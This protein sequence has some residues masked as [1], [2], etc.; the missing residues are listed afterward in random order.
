MKLKKIYVFTLLLACSMFWGQKA[1]AIEDIAPDEPIELNVEQSQLNIEPLQIK[2]STGFRGYLEHSEYLTGD[3]GG[4]RSKLEERGVNIQASYEVNSFIMRNRQEGKTKGTYQGVFTISTEFD[5]E[6]LGLWKGGTLF[7]SVEFMN[8]GTNSADFFNSFSEINSNDPGGINVHQIGE[9]WYE[10]V[11]GDDKFSL[12]VGRQDTNSEF[13]ALETGTEFIGVSHNIIPNSPILNPPCEQMGVRAKLKI[14]ENSYIQ[15][16]IFDAPDGPSRNPKGFFNGKNGYLNLNEVHYLADIKG[17]AGEYVLGG[18][19]H[20]GDA[21]KLDGE[22]FKKQNYGLY[23]NFEQKVLNSRKNE[24]GGLSVFGQFGYTPNTI[25]EIPF[26]FGGALVW[27][28]IGERRKDDKVGLG[29]SWYQ[30]SSILKDSDNLKSEKVIECFYSV[31]VT[32][33]LSVKPGFQYIMR[34]GGQFKDSFALG[35][36]SELTF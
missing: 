25:N 2:E 33:F 35:M 23:V 13:Q 17:Y 12:K 36:R 26:Y 7:G 14:T 3:W 20:T 32:N 10:H 29:F 24:D 34:P 27:S 16:G 1:H 28:G 30:P 15:S 4:L 6:K 19:V 11:F 5:T 31:K 22:G 9:L 18:W 8:K 21:E